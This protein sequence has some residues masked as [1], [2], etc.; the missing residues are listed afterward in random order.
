MAVLSCS[1]HAVDPGRSVNVLDAIISPAQVRVY[2]PD[3]VTEVELDAGP[4]R[5]SLW[6]DGETWHLSPRLRSG[7]LKC[8]AYK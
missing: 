7:Y 4:L 3:A 5:V 6:T 2:Y 8:I 1:H